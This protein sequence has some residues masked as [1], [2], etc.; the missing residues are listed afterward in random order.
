MGSLVYMHRARHRYVYQPP[1]LWTEKVD[2]LCQKLQLNRAVRLL[3]SGYVKMPMVIGHLKPIILIPVGLLAGMPAGQVEAVLLH[4]LAHIRRHD[5]VVNFM[6]TIAETVFF[7]N[8]GL[9]WISSLL[10]DERE[11]CCDDIALSQTKNKKEFVQALISFKEHALYGANYQVAFPG[12][13]NHLL[14]RVSRILH[15]KNKPFG[16]GEKAFF[17]VGV[18]ILSVIVATAAVAEVRTMAYIHTKMHHSFASEKIA[19]PVKTTKQVTVRSTRYITHIARPVVPTEMT[20]VLPPMPK[21]VPPSPPDKLTDQQRALIDQEQAKKDQEQARLDMIQAKKDQAQ[22]L[23][24]QEQAKKD[25][26]QAKKEQQDIKNQQNIEQAKRN[27][28]QAKRNAEQAQ[29]NEMQDIRNQE[30]AKRNQEQTERNK[31]QVRL[32][33]LQAQKNEEQAKR[34]E[35]QNTRNQE[36]ARKNQVSVQD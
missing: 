19:V 23:R 26:E 22:A 34:N 5:Y 21:A 9:L 7:F 1:A 18:L 27:E 16:P 32:N 14:N 30:Q 33:E 20:D 4:E 10:R 6:Q 2:A 28:E 13:K 25:E 36:L 24:D 17:M 31:E 12:K 11:N 15:N 29:K 35:E 3:E 8:P